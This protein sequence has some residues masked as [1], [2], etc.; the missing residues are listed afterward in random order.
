MKKL[1]GY[2]LFFFF[3]LYVR[4]MKPLSFKHGFC[5]FSQISQRMS[6]L[7]FARFWRRYV[8]SE[9][10]GVSPFQPGAALRASAAF[11]SS[12]DAHFRTF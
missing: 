8:S 4:R 7:V 9:F 6:F 11:L 5:P 10:I 3:F 1:F 12:G 2:W